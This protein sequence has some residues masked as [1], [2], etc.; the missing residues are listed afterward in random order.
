MGT[1]NGSDHPDRSNRSLQ[2]TARTDALGLGARRTKT[3]WALLVIVVAAVTWSLRG[4]GVSLS[5]LIT[6]WAGAKDLASGLFPP[7]LDEEL[8]RSVGAAVVETL[9]I[10]IAALFFGTILGIGLA[11]TMAGNM[12]APTWLAVGAR[13]TATVLRSVPELLWAL[14]FVAIVGLGPAAGVYAI[15]LHGTG[16]LAKLVSEQL[17]AV[18]PGPVEAMRVTGASRA[19]VGAFSIIPQSRS[20]IASL[21][22]Y[23]WECNIRSSAII[24]FVGAGGIGQ[25]LGIS[26][27]LFRYQELATLMIALLLLVLIVDQTSRILRRRMGAATA[28]AGKGLWGIYK[29]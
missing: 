16:L 27:R 20:D 18:D 28:R 14:L 7:Q 17:E 3:R 11:V 25:A 8:L 10:S 1:L 6:G 5:T 12:G 23:Q 24:G 21:V 2:S 22:L 29:C 19:A 26:M 13:F 15:S 4:T 9:Q